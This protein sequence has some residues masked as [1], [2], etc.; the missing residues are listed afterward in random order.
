MTRHSQPKVSIVIPAY[1]HAAYLSEAIDGI[2]AQDYPNV[3]LIVLNDGSTD[4]TERVLRQY[5]ADRFY[6]ET[7][8]N[9]GQSASLNKGWR[10][11]GGDILG[12][13][14]ADDKLRTTA[15]SR[16]I[17]CLVR[18]PHVAVCYCD[19]ELISSTSQVLRRVFAPEYDYHAMLERAVCPPG[20]GAFF[21]REAFEKA[22]PWNSEYRQMPDYDFWLR[23]G[24]TGPFQRIPEPLAYFRIHEGS[25]TFT[26]ASVARSEEALRII[27]ALYQRTDLPAD[28]A[29]SKT[30]ALS[31]ARLIA[32]L[33]HWR[34]GRYS[35]GLHELGRALKLRPS[36]LWSP[37]TARSVSSALLNRL[38]YRIAWPLGRTSTT[39][40]SAA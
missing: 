34:A 32:A 17:E 6:R 7:Q 31:N 19:Y 4:E 37:S 28:V 10:L 5:P 22:G 40:S 36:H 9:M 27:D 14:S 39:R 35:A 2:L 1:N 38:R 26:P 33:Y 11:A 3:E 13:L 29:T 12:Y 18:N 8:P 24:L 25:Q 30:E 21:R 20:P 23:M 15:V 16:S